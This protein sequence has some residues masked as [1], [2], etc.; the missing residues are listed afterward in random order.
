GGADE[1]ALGRS[2]G[3]ARAG[4]NGVD[5]G[6]ERR[7][8]AAAPAG[9]SDGACGRDLH[10]TARLPCSLVHPA[11]L[12]RPRDPDELRGSE[13]RSH[14]GGGDLGARRPDGALAS[15]PRRRG[16]AGTATAAAMSDTVVFIPAWNEEEN[17]PAVLDDLRR[18]LPNADV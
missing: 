1:G 11:P 14:T 5:D 15:T 12:R 17:L 10:A 16:R 8:D 18:E 13:T 4:A 3:R 6:G 7:S 2:G 9:P